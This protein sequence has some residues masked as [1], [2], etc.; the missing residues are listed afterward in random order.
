MAT[1]EK[2]IEA[3]ETISIPKNKWDELEAKMAALEKSNEEL[4]NPGKPQKAEWVSHHTAKMATWNGE[5]VT[6]IGQVKMN[7]DQK[8]PAYGQDILPLTLRSLN[9]ETSDLSVPYLTFMREAVRIPVSILKEERI[10]RTETDLRKGG[11]GVGPK[12]GHVVSEGEFKGAIME[13]GRGETLEY[14]VTFVDFTW[15]VRVMDGEYQGVELHL[16]DK[17]RA[18]NP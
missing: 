8:S 10:V 2:K 12:K 9:G 11:G 17:D 14:A 3:P 5:L 4:K 7:L 1:E 18:L 16:T 6:K 15:D 13:G